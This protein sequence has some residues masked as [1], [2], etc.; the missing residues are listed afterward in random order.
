MRKQTKD[1]GRNKKRITMP[2]L[3]LLLFFLVAAGMTIISQKNYERN[4]LSVTV[5][6]PVKKRLP[7]KKE[8]MA[9]YQE[10][11]DGGVIQW[12]IGEEAEYAK[13]G[14]VW[15]YPVYLENQI[16]ESGQLIPYY[17][18]G[19]G[20]QGLGISVVKNLETGG[21]TMETKV[22][23]DSN[24]WAEEE[25]IMAVVSYMGMQ[26]ESVIPCSAV[27]NPKIPTESSRIYV[28]EKIPKV[29]GT[30]LSIQSMPVMILET[31]GIEAAI[32]NTILAD[33]VADA[34]ALGLYE[35]IQVKLLEEG[36]SESEEE[37][38]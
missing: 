7:Y 32:D 29:W 19:E 11:S 26:R 27:I 10:T 24:R 31:N 14:E 28:I 12:E 16:T 23:T 9:V 18:K 5:I 4:L 6:H 25:Q 8:Y 15:I 20:K 36:E 17:V 2:V 21:Y 1:K 3:L 22:E 37:K 33:I 38:E 34:K 13:N 30:A 35:G